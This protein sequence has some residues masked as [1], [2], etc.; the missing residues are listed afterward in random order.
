MAYVDYS[1]IA[2]F[3]I[4]AVSAMV[5]II[6][7]SIRR[8]HAIIYWQSLV[9][10]FIAFISLAATPRV[11]PHRES[12][13]LIIDQYSLYFMGLIL[14]L[15][16]I[17]ATFS[18]IYLRHFNDHK[19]ELYVLITI[20]AM[21]GMVLASS[22]NF[23]SLFLGF[24][25]LS[26]TLYVMIGFLRD[27][28][29][30][31]EAAIKYLILAAAASAFLVLGMAFIYAETGTLDFTA[32]I[33]II[34]SSDSSGWL[35]LFMG[36]GLIIVGLGFK[37][38]VVPFHMWTPDIY[39]G[40]SAPVTAFIASV[41]K[42]AM[43]AFLIRYFSYIDFRTSAGLVFIFA[44]IAVLS[45]LAGNLL[46]IIQKNIKRLLAYS[47]IA[48]LGYILV[49]LVAL[50]G[51]SAEAI[52]Y[53]ITV[54]SITITGAFGLIAFIS[55]AGEETDDIESYR[56]LFWRKPLAAGLL[57]IL[58]FSLAGIPLTA[59]F[60]GKYYIVLA[61]IG[62]ALWFPVIVLIVSSVIGL[63]YYLRVIAIMVESSE[64][65]T[66][67]VSLPKFSVARALVLSIVS[68][69]ILLLGIFPAPLIA[70][71]RQALFASAF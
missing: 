66:E 64:T 2:P 4:M 3:V 59:G 69:L 8:N 39:Q 20:S 14:I 33:N 63:Y 31:L 35:Y 5:A 57:A 70:L 50:G 55:H 16:A 40:A 51:R 41:S 6:L 52:I 61:G 11:A 15:S 34:S 19:E 18:Y 12:T 22:N 32:A 37:I 54:Y 45:M 62:K 9:G 47:S 65:Q 27:S 23:V 60:I 21:G 48:H 10:M 58:L 42:T 38:G 43:V 53:Y 30:N 25:I 17:A 24:E 28:V 13:I 67:T 49:G 29:F 56:G 71:I 46:A 26:V 36:T 68:L 1:A 44:A 7:I